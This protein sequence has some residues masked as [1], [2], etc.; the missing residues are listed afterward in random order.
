MLSA[1]YLIT[2]NSSDQL[3]EVLYSM[4]KLRWHL[5]NHDFFEK[6]ESESRLFNNQTSLTDYLV[7]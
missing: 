7:I 5:K 3:W 1:F 2:I 4:T 6:Y